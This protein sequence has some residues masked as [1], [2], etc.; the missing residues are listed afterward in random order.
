FFAAGFFA[1]V[2]FL[3]GAAFLRRAGLVA[4]VCFR[5][6]LVFAFAFFFAAMASSVRYEIRTNTSQS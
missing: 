2:F 4:G 6:T 1:A 5:F 3:T